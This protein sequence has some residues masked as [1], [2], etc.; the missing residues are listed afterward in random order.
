MFGIG[1]FVH[2]TALVAAIGIGHT[3]A[4]TIG[5][6]MMGVVLRRRL[7]E[8][9]F[10]HALPRTAVIA[11]A[12]AFAAWFAHQSIEPHAQA[13]ALAF[14]AVVG[15]L[16]GALYL[17]VVRATRRRLRQLPTPVDLAESPDLVFDE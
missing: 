1:A 16:G 14:L 13:D 7:G 8:P 17:S 4:Y 3:I 5:A 12:F 2:G 15:V 9:I 6:V 10:P 11:G